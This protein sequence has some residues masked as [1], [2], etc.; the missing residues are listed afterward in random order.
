VDPACRLCGRLVL[1]SRLSALG[2]A[3][4]RPLRRD[5]ARDGRKR[6]LAHAAPERLQVLRE[7]APAVL[8]HRGR[9]HRAR[10]ERVGGAPLAGSH[11][12]PWRAPRV[13]GRK[14]FVRPASGPVCGRSRGEQRDLRVH[15]APADSR[16]GPFRLHVG[17]GLRL[18]RRPKRPG[19]RSGAPPLDAA[20]MGRRGARGSQQGAGRNRSARGRSGAIRSDRA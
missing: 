10:P 14:S 9:F 1:Q 3:R 13:L 12:L 8:D 18:R 5:S 19:G 7:A 16:Y 4:R 2:Q 15:R 17:I 20:R 6:R 11:G